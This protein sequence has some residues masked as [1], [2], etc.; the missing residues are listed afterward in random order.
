M[1]FSPPKKLVVYG[2]AD[3]YFAGLWGHENP[4]DPIFDRSRTVFVVTFS[5]CSLFWVSKLHT[6]ITL[7][8]LH[9]DYVVLSHYV[10]E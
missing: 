4:Q 7:S 2:H 9:S 8:T 3:K 5:N 10:R 1:V 6:N